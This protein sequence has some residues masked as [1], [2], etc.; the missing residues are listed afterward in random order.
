MMKRYSRRSSSNDEAV[1]RIAAALQRLDNARTSLQ[2]A[3]DDLTSEVNDL[4]TPEYVQKDFERFWAAGGASLQQYRDWISE[5]RPDRPV[6]KR[7][8]LRLV[9]NQKQRHRGRLVR[10]RLD[11]SDDDPAA[12]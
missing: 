4:D 10:R 11:G 12:A 5:Q 9:S 7:R 3:S 1:G 8:H 2:L 6:L